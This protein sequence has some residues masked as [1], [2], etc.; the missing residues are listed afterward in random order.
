MDQ[1]QEGVKRPQRAVLRPGAPWMQVATELS[2]RRGDVRRGGKYIKTK[3]L[4]EKE[5]S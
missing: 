2:P 1:G 5:K 3:H 4:A